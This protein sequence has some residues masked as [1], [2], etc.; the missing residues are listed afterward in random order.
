M[1]SDH[2]R[3]VTD[4]ADVMTLTSLEWL[5]RRQQLTQETTSCVRLPSTSISTQTPLQPERGALATHSVFD[6]RK[7][8][9]SC[10]EWQV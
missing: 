4:P 9:P 10:H 1:I 3:A 7:P 2:L 6:A 5:T 8:A